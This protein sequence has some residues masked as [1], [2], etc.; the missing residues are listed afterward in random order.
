MSIAKKYNKMNPFTFQTPK[1]FEYVSLETLFSKNG[2]KTVYPVKALYINKKSQ[3]GDAPVAITDTCMVNL[4][5]HLLDTVN[6][7]F[8]DEELISGVNNDLFGF[9]IYSYYPRNNNKKCYSV[10]WVDIEK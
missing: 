2:A 3:Y 4:P 7:M 6:E 8:E 10:T 9:I 5:A 1:D